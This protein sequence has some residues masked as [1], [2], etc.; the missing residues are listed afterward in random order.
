MPNSPTDSSIPDQSHRPNL[1]RAVIAS[2]VGTAIEWYDFFLFGT[3]AG[4]V[5]AKE[6]TTATG[7]A[8]RRRWWRRCC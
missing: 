5:F 7:W 6:F 1:V 8:A 4:L 2:T 3:M